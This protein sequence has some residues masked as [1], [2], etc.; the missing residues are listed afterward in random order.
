LNGESVVDVSVKKL[1]LQPVLTL[2]PLWSQSALQGGKNNSICFATA[3][4]ARQIP[5]AVHCRGPYSLNS[6]GKK[7]IYLQV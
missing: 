5:L 4:E 1:V 3:S 2:Q 6:K 7:T